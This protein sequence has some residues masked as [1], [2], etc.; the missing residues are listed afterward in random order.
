[1]TYLDT[2]SFLSEKARNYLLSSTMT[3]KKHHRLCQRNIRLLVCGWTPN[4]LR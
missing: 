3:T 4:R 2:C 1:M